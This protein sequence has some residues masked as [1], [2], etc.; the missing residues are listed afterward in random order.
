[1]NC[2]PHIER[3]HYTAARTSVKQ[4]YLKLQLLEAEN[5]SYY[6][7]EAEGMFVLDLTFSSAHYSIDKNRCKLFDSSRKIGDI[8]TKKGTPQCGGLI[9]RT[10]LDGKNV[11]I[12]SSAC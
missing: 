6:I 9:N 12:G 10:F 7:P 2:E 4:V 1:M 5:S 8:S 3:T 11:W